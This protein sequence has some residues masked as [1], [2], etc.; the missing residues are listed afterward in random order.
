MIEI[1]LPK[2]WN[3]NMSYIGTVRPNKVSVNLSITPLSYASIDLSKG[4]NLPSRGFVELFSSMGSLGIFRVRSPQDAYGDYVTTAELEHA[5]VEVGDYLVMEKI[6][7]M[8]PARQAMQRVFSHYRGS[9]WQLGSVT[10]L[11]T[12]EIAVQVNHERV[13]EAMLA[14]LAQKP[15]CYMSFDFTTS[16]WT[17]NIVK[18]DETVSAEGRLARNLNYAKV[19]Y[20]DTELCTRAVYEVDITG[21]DDEPTTEWRTRNA[22]TIGTY[23]VVEREVYLGTDL[24]DDEIDLAVDTFLEKHKEPSISVEISAQE[25]SGITGESYDM[26]TIGKLCRLALVDYGVTIE[27]TVTGLSWDNVY[28]APLDI[29][30]RLAEAED[31][32]INFLH[33]VDT[34]GGTMGG[35]GGGHG[36]GG[37]GGG[38]KAQADKWKEYWTRLQQTDHFVDIQ[39]AHVDRHDNILQQAGMYIDSSGVLQYALDN[40]RNIG[41][42]L[43]V[44]ADRISLVVSGTGDNATIKA[45]SIVASINGTSSSVKISADK[46][47]IDGDTTISGALN[48]EKARLTNLMSG[49][50]TATTIRSTNL[51]VGGSGGGSMHFMGSNVGL[52]SC[53]DAAGNAHSVLGIR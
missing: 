24:T 20:D 37:G 11:G 14:L 52:Y 18:R 22:D 43:K 21:D 29:T 6:E 10:A 2:V 44:E 3:K 51:Y 33:D 49:S 42:K 46:V 32:V 28:D 13:L 34:H 45:A 26:F 31:T 17:V 27:R 40:E 15:N 7:E 5:I 50:T 8:L 53:V 23:G 39:A 25:L 48:A 35:S 4:E 47:Y 16:P 38:V 1:P 30:V 36:G 19:I 12:G 41:S 9:R